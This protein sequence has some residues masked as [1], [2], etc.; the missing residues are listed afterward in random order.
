MPRKLKTAPELANLALAVMHYLADRGAG[1]KIGDLAEH[2]DVTPEDVVS[3]VKYLSNAV[4]FNAKQGGAEEQFYRVNP[5]VDYDLEDDDVD[6][7]WTVDTEIDFASGDRGEVPFDAP[8]LSASQVSALIAGLQYLKSL[9]GMPLVAEAEELIAKLSEGSESEYRTTI[10]YRPGT[11]SATVAILREAIMKK[12]R[13]SCHYIDKD[14]KES[15]RVLDPVRIDPRDAN[16]QLRSWCHTRNDERNFRIDNLSNLVMLEDSWC[17]EAY[18]LQTKNEADYIA[19]ETD[20]D[21][22]IEV[23]PEAYSLISD[24]NAKVTKHD[25]KTGV[26]T[27]KVKIGSLPF[28]GRTVAKFAGAARVLS[29]ENAREAVRDYARA[30]LDHQ[31]RSVDNQ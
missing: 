11:I 21:V 13:I 16:W 9:P 31:A 29:P 14:G 2:F 20:V 10:E 12:R 22:T 30:A 8:R 7:E 17:D 28:F 3:C 27:A 15:D 26:K 4:Y 19:S 1:V 5:D 6:L 18:A 25:K 24:F 23:E